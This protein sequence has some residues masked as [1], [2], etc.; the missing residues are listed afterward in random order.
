MV[1]TKRPFLAALANQPSMDILAFS[2]IFGLI[3][4][5]HGCFIRSISIT[6]KNRSTGMSADLGRFQSNVK[7]NFATLNLWVLCC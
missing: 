5:L 3:E 7:N 6:A 1:I 4:Q 2:S